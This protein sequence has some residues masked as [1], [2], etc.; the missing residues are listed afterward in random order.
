MRRK[1]D[2]PRIVRH[3]PCEIII[4]KLDGDETKNLIENL[5]TYV[6]NLLQQRC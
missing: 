3:R 4:M 2:L 1:D 6:E 5:I